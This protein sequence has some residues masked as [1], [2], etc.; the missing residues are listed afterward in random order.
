MLVRDCNLVELSHLQELF[1]AKWT[2]A[3]IGWAAEQRYRIAVRIS[4]Q[5]GIQIMGQSHGHSILG[6]EGKDGQ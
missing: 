5:G 2:E 4:E 3:W 6:S 1:D